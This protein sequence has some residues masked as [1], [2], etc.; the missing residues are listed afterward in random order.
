MQCSM[1]KSGPHDIGVYSRPRFVQESS[2]HRWTCLT[3]SKTCQAL[4]LCPVKPWQTVEKNSPWSGDLRR[5]RGADV[6]PLLCHSWDWSEKYNRTTPRFSSTLCIFCNCHAI[7]CLGR[8]YYVIKYQIFIYGVVATSLRTN[9]SGSCQR[10][11]FE[12]QH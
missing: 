10:H 11:T 8:V 2:D 12:R 9:N 7:Q 4:M 1:L 5:R 6:K 3:E